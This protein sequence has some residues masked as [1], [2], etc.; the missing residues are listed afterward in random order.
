MN[1]TIENR[2]GSA[3]SKQYFVDELAQILA[4]YGR[5][6]RSQLLVEKGCQKSEASCFVEMETLQQAFAAHKSLNMLLLPASGYLF[7]F[8]KLRVDFI[9]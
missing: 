7:F 1:A 9:E 3:E 2:L 5:I 6:K 8:V 4:P